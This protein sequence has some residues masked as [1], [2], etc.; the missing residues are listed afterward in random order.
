MKISAT[1]VVGIL[2]LTVL[3]GC[4]GSG[5][6]APGPTKIVFTSDRN[7]TYDIFL[8]NADGT[9]LVALVTAGTD[10]T[11]PSLSPNG[12][13]LACRS[14][15]FGHGMQVIDLAQNTAELIDADGQ[16]PKWSPDGTKIAYYKTVNGFDQIFV[17]D[18]NT[19]TKTQLTSGNF[20]NRFPSWKPDG[21]KIA[22][23]TNRD[24]NFEIYVMN[25]DGSNPM[26]IT[27]HNSA[28]DTAPAWSPDGSKIAFSS[29]RS[30][31]FD[32][33]VMTSEGAS[34]MPLAAHPA[35]DGL[36]SWSAD[37]TQIVF[38]SDRDSSLEIYRVN[39]DGT[40]L[41]NLTNDPSDDNQPSF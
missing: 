4:S 1:L 9:G 3:A 14:D 37:G 8:M 40:N 41:V 10:D 25:S 29:N 20:D 18:L 2:T 22:F 24:G 11:Q 19:M 16:Y 13:K 35:Y 28:I 17:A 36:P 39:V 26:R 7:G 5:G 21:T 23:A 33:H 6:S 30:G 32:I 15:G 34:P 38:E 31:N 27:F 12:K